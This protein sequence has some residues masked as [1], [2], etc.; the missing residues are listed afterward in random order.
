MVVHPSGPGR[1]RRPVTWQA[2]AVVLA[3]ALADAAAGAAALHQ[4]VQ[5]GRAFSQKA[6]EIGVGDTI[7]FTN[8]DEFL[9]QIY[10]RSEQFQ[11]E[12]A[13]QP[14]GETVDVRFPVSGS[15]SVECEIHPKMHLAV[16][17]K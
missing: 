10:V 6:I 4:I 11:F 1:R 5:K 8:D 16:T 9:H 7:S 12:S 17:V 13:E 3:L 14:P 15:F 2:L